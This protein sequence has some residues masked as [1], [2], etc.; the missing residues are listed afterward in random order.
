MDSCPL[1][2][3][4]RPSPSALDLAIPAAVERALVSPTRC[5]GLTPAFE[6]ARVQSVRHAPTELGGQRGGVRAG[7]ARVRAAKASAGGACDHG[8]RGWARSAARWWRRGEQWRPRALESRPRCW[9]CCCCGGSAGWDVPGARGSRQSLSPRRRP[10]K[11]QVSS[12]PATEENRQWAAGGFSLWRGP[13]ETPTLP[14][15]WASTAGGGLW[16]D[17]PMRGAAPLFWICAGRAHSWVPGR[18]LRAD[19]TPGTSRERGTRSAPRS[20]PRLVRFPGPQRRAG[21]R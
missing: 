19:C 12:P 13:S 14:R 15:A 21:P 11:P 7:R 5:P 3:A 16:G 4:P 18:N 20:F 2:G 9:G 8:A 17:D 6:S 10:A 1:Q